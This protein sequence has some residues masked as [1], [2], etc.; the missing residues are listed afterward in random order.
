VFGLNSGGEHDQGQA[1]LLAKHPDYPALFGL[2]RLARHFCGRAV[3]FVTHNWGGGIERHID[4]MIAKARAEGVSV[5]LLQIDRTRNLEVHV[6]YR[7]AEFLY[8]PNLDS[9]YLPRDAAE[10]AAF[11]A[12]LAP[13]LIHGHSLAGLRW[14]A[15]RALMDLVSAS[16]RPYA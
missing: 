9:L 3:L 5:V 8:L 1:A 14:A 6:A 11:V 16:G 12:Q 10:L 2:Y 4:D 13:V 15:A 7:S